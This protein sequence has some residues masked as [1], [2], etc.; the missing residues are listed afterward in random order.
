[1]L[2]YEARWCTR[3]L[4]FLQLN[5]NP[6]LPTGGPSTFFPLDIFP[7]PVKLTGALAGPRAGVRL[8]IWGMKQRA[9]CSVLRAFAFGAS[10][11]D[12]VLRLEVVAA[13]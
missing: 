5:R 12:V 7:A 11:I 2:P 3:A 1:M 4:V 8:G 10:R 9:F 6:P 13:A